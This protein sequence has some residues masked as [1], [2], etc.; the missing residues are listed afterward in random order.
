MII[1]LA[2][3]KDIDQGCYIN[4]GKTLNKVN[5]TSPH[6]RIS[7]RCEEIKESC[8]YKLNSLISFSFEDHPNLTTIGSSSFQSCIHLSIANLSSCIKLITV[9]SYAFSSCDEISMILLPTGLQEIQISAFQ[10]DKLLTSVIIPASVKIIGST[11]F[12][13]CVN[14][15]NV[16]FEEGS[17]LLTLEWAVF[18]GCSISSFQIPE[19]VTNVDGYAF[20]DGKLTNLTLHPKNEYL[21]VENNTVF[22]ADKCI[23]FFISNKTFETYEIPSFVST[24]G[25][26][27]LYKSKITAIAIPENVKRIEQICF[28]DCKNL[29]NV[30][31]LGPLENI[32]SNIF[33]LSNNIELIVF[34]NT[35]MK[36]EGYEFISNRSPKIRMKFTCKIRFNYNSIYR[37]TNVSISYL[38]K[39][40]LVIDKNTLIMDSDQTKI[41]EFWGFN[42]LKITIPK[43]V[44]R[45]REGAFENSTIRQIDFE[46]DSQLVEIEN[47]VFRN[48][49]MLGSINFSS[50]YL[51]SLGFSA[52]KDC[53]LLSSVS[54][55]SSD[56]EVMNNAFEN[57]INLESVN[58]MNNILDNCFSG[59]T[60]L[61]QINIKEGSE[62]I[63]VGSFENCNSLEKLNIPSS[64]K[65]I[66]DYAFINC[67]NLKTIFFISNNL[68]ENFSINSF[69]GCIS[70]TNITD[71]SSDNYECNFNTIYYKNNSKLDLVYHARNS[72]DKVLIV[73]CNTICR[74]SFNH[75]NNIKNI[76]ISPNSVSHI[77]EFSFNNCP[78]LRYINFPLS[79]QT[80][81]AYAFNECRSIRCPINIENTSV[82][83]L[84]MISESGISSKLVFSCQFLY[85][86]NR[87]KVKFQLFNSSANLFWRHLSN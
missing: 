38:D 59:C 53:I 72:L 36:V 32:G 41:Y 16:T 54:F 23:L 70:L 68:L 28:C 50:L 25:Q 21:F 27:C 87:Q 1:L 2:L 26:G 48:C 77:E 31:F 42:V 71:F 85:D 79:I 44:S 12:S 24:L 78:Q 65:I 29:I 13:D 47:Y 62:I 14:L 57:C 30:T 3:F 33:A 84:K 5:D 11:A 55:A 82:D 43:T 7:A 45:I 46:K 9:S 6:L 39:L 22:S 60:N 15:K 17:N 52:L 76:S 67:N 66:S 49:S 86:S 81:A 20:T 80:V 63:G 40:D 37:I 69:S 83:Y 19:K 74:F 35:T 56:V 34:P 61:S 4:D 73:S 64:V 8:F 18:S 51:R 75:S 10:Y 58:F